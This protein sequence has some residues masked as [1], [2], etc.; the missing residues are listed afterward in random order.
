MFERRFP[1]S[2]S[3]ES[4]T[5][6]LPEFQG[7]PVAVQIGLV[8]HPGF[9][10]LHP[11]RALVALQVLRDRLPPTELLIDPIFLPAAPAKAQGQFGRQD[12]RLRGF[13]LGT[14]LGAL[15]RA[16]AALH[17][18][19]EGSQALFFLLGKLFIP[20]SLQTV[21]KG[22]NV[23]HNYESSSASASALRLKIFWVR[24]ACLLT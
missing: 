17:D 11:D 5:I 20:L 15:P 23:R 1:H 24:S 12:P 10:D 8:I 2:S 18:H 19:P 21:V 7:I 6:N 16:V 14:A 9:P 4:S 3:L 22:N 13:Q